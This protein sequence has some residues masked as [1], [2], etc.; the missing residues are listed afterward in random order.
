MSNLTELERAV[1]DKILD[2][3]H[4][5]LEILRNQL[6]NDRV[7][8]REMTGTGFFTYFNVGDPPVA[9]VEKIV[10]GDVSADIEGVHHGAGFLVWVEHGRLIMLEGFTYDDPWPDEIEQYTLKYLVPKQISDD[11]KF[12]SYRKDDKRDWE[13]LIKQ[14]GPR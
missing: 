14:I 13:A 2:G 9:D 10:F 1:L 11:G 7:S 4:P 6:S 8:R 3:D 12:I 5:L